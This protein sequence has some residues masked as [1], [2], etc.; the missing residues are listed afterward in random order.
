MWKYLPIALALAIF[1]ATPAL[2]GT[3]RHSAKQP[4]HNLHVSAIRSSQGATTGVGIVGT[5]HNSVDAPDL[6]CVQ[7]TFG[8]SIALAC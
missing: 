7:H 4:T 2:A 6:D 5:P 3:I 1:A 8:T